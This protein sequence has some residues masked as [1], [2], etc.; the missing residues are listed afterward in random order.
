MLFIRFFET[1]AHFYGIGVEVKGMLSHC[2]VVLVVIQ[3][4]LVVIY[5]GML[6][7]VL[8]RMRMVSGGGEMQKW[9]CVQCIW[10]EHIAIIW[11]GYLFLR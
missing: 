10:L 4:V 5:E 6:L 9:R 1:R 3:V 8:Q 7:M 11:V 2:Q